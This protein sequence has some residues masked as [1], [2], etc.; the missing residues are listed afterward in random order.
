MDEMA[1][2]VEQMEPKPMNIMWKNVDKI[3]TGFQFKEKTYFFKGNNFYEFDEE[4]Q[5]INLDQP[6]N[7]LEFWMNCPPFQEYKV[8]ISSA[9]TVQCSLVFIFLVSILC[10]MF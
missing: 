9:I 8:V 3:D 7:A 6:Q 1:I 4:K 10:Q 2:K 5:T